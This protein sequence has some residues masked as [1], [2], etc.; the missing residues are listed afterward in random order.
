M[1]L[2][3]DVVNV[4]LSTTFNTQFHDVSLRQ[5]HIIRP[6]CR[7]ESSA[8][9]S[10]ASEHGSRA[11]SLEMKAFPMS[12]MSCR[13]VSRLPECEALALA[14]LG[15][16]PLSTLTSRSSCRTRSANWT[17]ARNVAPR[18]HAGPTLSTHVCTQRWLYGQAF[19]PRFR[20]AQSCSRRRVRWSLDCRIC[21]CEGQRCRMSSSEADSMDPWSPSSRRARSV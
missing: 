12:A 20:S 13:Y 14:V 3:S 11:S 21:K 9:V 8:I 6:H 10:A 19:S 16:R 1:R 17:F 5:R 15:Y 4:Q 7:S 2:L 18:S